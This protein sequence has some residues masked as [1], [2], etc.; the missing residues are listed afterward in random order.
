[1]SDSQEGLSEF[2]EIARADVLDRE[3]IRQTQMDA[4]LKILRRENR[5]YAKALAKQEE[6]FDRFVEVSRVPVDVPKFVVPKQSKRLP[7]RS[8]VVPIY[9]QQYGQMVRPADTPGG[10]GKFNS[11][12]YDQRAE[13]WFEGVTSHLRA[14]AK[15]YR[16]EELIIVL[17]GDQVEGDEIYPQQ[18]WQLELDPMM[19]MFEL[20]CKMGGDS[21][22]NLGMLQRL[23]RF[24]KEELGVRW[25]A[26]YAVPGNHG[27]VGGKRGGARPKTYNWDVGLHMLLR[28]KLRAEPID[29]FVI[30]PAGSVFFYAAGFECQAIHG[31]TIRG[32]GGI[33][34]YGIARHDAKSVRLHNRLYRYLFM[35]HIHQQS[36]LNIGTGAE[37]IISGDWVGA[38][39]MSDQIVAASRPKQW[40]IYFSA[41][42]GVA[43]QVPIYLTEADEALMPSP[44]YGNAVVGSAKDLRAVA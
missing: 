22:G 44:I 10:H 13:R 31:E 40:L 23:V 37:A 32:W 15:I 42:M 6:L 4:E 25:I 20:A 1:M 8:V 16:I 38:N 29:E 3:R 28:D 5:E 9:D 35:G 26:V 24:A 33:P 36:Q 30:E 17:G 18:P 39:N 2:D 19:Q 21:D 11:A 12:I 14:E 43:D 41:S 34:F 27:K 7:A